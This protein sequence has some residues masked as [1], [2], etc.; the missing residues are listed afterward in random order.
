MQRANL[1]IIVDM[2]VLMGRKGER[3]PMLRHKS[4]DRTV[5]RAAKTCRQR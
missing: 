4:Y 2:D 1:E 3:P 5:T